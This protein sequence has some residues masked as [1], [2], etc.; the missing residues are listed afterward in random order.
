M[1]ILPRIRHVGLKGP[2]RREEK[3]PRWVSSRKPNFLLAAPACARLAPLAAAPLCPGAI[4]GDLQVGD[5]AGF[6]ELRHGAE[7]LPHQLGGWR[8][9]DEVAGRVDG[10]TRCRAC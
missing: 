7:D 8:R 4:A 9:A 5:Q 6:L 1:E 3:P 10:S 2:P